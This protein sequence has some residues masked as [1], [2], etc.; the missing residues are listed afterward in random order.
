[1]QHVKTVKP[2]VFWI[3]V[4]VAAALMTY[5]VSEVKALKVQA[6]TLNEAL[7]TNATAR[8]SVP[9]VKAVS[10]GAE[11]PVE[12]ADIMTKLQRHAN[13]LFFAGKRENWPLADF[14][15]EEIEETVKEV[16]KK[17]I[18]DG[19]VNVSGLMPALIL[20]EILELERAVSQK[21]VPA[22]NSHYQALTASCN[23]C[24]VATRRAYLVI[25]SPRTPAY[26]NQHYE[27]L[28]GLVGTDGRIALTN[29]LPR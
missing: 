15:V 25:D 9:V 6:R 21:D 17:N 19:P 4:S 22:F 26:D 7:R 24:H 14:Y 20:P 29:A 16:A 5:L 8:A 28:E 18:L 11:E 13:K 27:P 3:A 10:V 1:L 2:F 23:A 12:I